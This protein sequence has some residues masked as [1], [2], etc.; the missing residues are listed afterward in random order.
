MRL[1]DLIDSFLLLPSSCFRRF[2]AYLLSF[3]AYEL[4]APGFAAE[5]IR[6]RRFFFPHFDVAA[7]ERY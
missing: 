7:A 6:L 1:C 5:M 3:D 4:D 2:R